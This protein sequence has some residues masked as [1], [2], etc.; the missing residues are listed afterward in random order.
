VLCQQTKL[1]KNSLPFYAL[2]FKNKSEKSLT[3]WA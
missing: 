3:L 2:F 1:N